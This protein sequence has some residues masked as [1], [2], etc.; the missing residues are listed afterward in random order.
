M[1][2]MVLNPRRKKKRTSKRKRSRKNPVNL[3]AR[4]RR[5]TTR[6]RRTRRNPAA[7]SIFGRKADIKKMAI[8][9]G[10]VVGGYVA[11]AM[12]SKMIKEKLAGKVPD[13][14]ADLAVPAAFFFLRGKIP[15]GDLMAL[16]SFAR[17]TVALGR[18][19]VPQLGIEGLPYDD[20]MALTGE[21][22]AGDQ[23]YIES[24]H[25]EPVKNALPMV[26]VERMAR[27]IQ[28]L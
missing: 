21:I 9:T 1:E 14:V 15:Y 25:Y 6:R 28:T 3:N 4:K 5:K 8:A 11:S 10:A 18:R 24:P 12:G 16:G 23:Q 13:I 22:Y 20:A 17:G 19:Y 2:T 26:N 27:V 7:I